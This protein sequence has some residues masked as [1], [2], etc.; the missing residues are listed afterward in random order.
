MSGIAL[1]VPVLGMGV[2]TRT[3]SSAVLLISTVCLPLE[4]MPVLISGTSS[5]MGS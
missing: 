1:I 2:F 5:A 3:F 4:E